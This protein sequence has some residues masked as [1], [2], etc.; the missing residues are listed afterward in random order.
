MKRRLMANLHAGD[1]EE[2]FSTDDEGS[3]PSSSLA[4]VNHNSSSSPVP[5]S[6]NIY[7]Q[8][9]APCVL[10]PL[11]SKTRSGGSP[12]PPPPREKKEVRFAPSPILVLSDDEELTAKLQRRRLDVEARSKICTNQPDTEISGAPSPQPPPPPQ[13]QQQSTSAS[14]SSSP[15]PPVYGAPPPPPIIE[16]YTPQS[17]PPVK[18]SAFVPPTP[19]PQPQSTTFQQQQQQQQQSPPPPTQSSSSTP[20]TAQVGGLCFSLRV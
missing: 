3:R 14:F 6:R 17:Y 2:P 12:V 7:Q 13:Q 1:E 10:P 18:S 15:T 5:P 9:F 19:P 20:S 11:E 4:M 8:P 16:T